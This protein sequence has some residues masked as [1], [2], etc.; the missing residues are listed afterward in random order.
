MILTI[1]NIKKARSKETTYKSIRCN[2]IFVSVYVFQDQTIFSIGDV[3]CL[4]RTEP[5]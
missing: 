1:R 5:D 4:P 3:L 2:R